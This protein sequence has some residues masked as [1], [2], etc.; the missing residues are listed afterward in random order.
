[1]CTVRRQ[2]DFLYA[3]KNLFEQFLSL[4]RRRT[5]TA[6]AI[7]RR[8][9]SGQKRGQSVFQRQTLTERRKRH[10]KR[11]NGG[12]ALATLDTITTI[13]T[14]RKPRAGAANKRKG[15]DGGAVAWLSFIMFAL[16]RRQ[17]A[18]KFAR[19]ALA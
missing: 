9:G 10:R 7:P 5:V 2:R 15:K 13:R 17:N 1:M 12:N 16:L 6:G 8:S 4:Y 11:K 19:Y 14:A 3:A 18:G